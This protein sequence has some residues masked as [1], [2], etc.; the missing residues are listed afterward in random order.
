MPFFTKKELKNFYEERDKNLSKNNIN[1]HIHQLIETNIIRRIGHG[2]YQLGKTEI[3]IPPLHPKEVEL[4]QKLITKFPSI[5]YCLWDS[6]ILKTFTQ[7]LS[8]ASFQILEVE[9]DV[10]EAVFHFLKTINKNTFLKPTSQ[11]IENYILDLEDALILLP[12]VTEAPT[13]KVQSVST[14]TLEKMLVDLLS[15]KKLFYYY[16]GEEI[17]FIFQRAFDNYTVNESRLLRYAGRRKKKKQIKQILD[18]I[19]R[20]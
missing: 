8:Y 11:L 14:I 12:L 19:K 16:Q 18:S 3:F 17:S 5:S 13:Q 6:T 4:G 2:K 7:H 9:K 10:I 1:W 15:N 20:H